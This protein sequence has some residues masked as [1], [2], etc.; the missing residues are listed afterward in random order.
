MARFR[1]K[2]K[3]IDRKAHECYARA[4]GFYWLPCPVCNEWF[5]G[6]EQGK[7]SAVYVE[8]VPSEPYRSTS[9]CPNC[10]GYW[11]IRSVQVER[12]DWHRV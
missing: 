9:T 8:P 6:H 12:P 7:G 2:L 4:N 3:E 1:K 11:E 10:P 5:G